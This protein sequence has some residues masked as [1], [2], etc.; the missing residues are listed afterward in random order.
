MARSSTSQGSMPRPPTLRQLWPDSWHNLLYHRNFITRPPT[1]EGSYDHKMRPSQGSFGRIF[2]ILVLASLDLLHQK[3]VINIRL[4][5]SVM[6]RRSGH[7][8]AV[9]AG[10]SAPKGSCVNTCY[11]IGQLC[12]NNPAIAGQDVLHQRAVMTRPST[13]EGRYPQKSWPSQEGYEKIFCITSD[14]SFC[15]KA[16]YR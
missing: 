6:T 3:V 16:I 8:W 12:P 2:S 14:G 13:S 7:C 10:F 9:M 11:I 15:I 4:A 5:I 1:S